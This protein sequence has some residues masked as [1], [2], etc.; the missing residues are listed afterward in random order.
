MTTRTSI[1]Q[2]LVSYSNAKAQIA[3]LTRKLGGMERAQSEIEESLIAALR[4]QGLETAVSAGVEVS[5]GTRLSLQVSDPAMWAEWV[6]ENRAVEFL[7]WTGLRISAVEQYELDNGE[8]PPGLARSTK[9]SV[10]VGRA[11]PQAITTLLQP[12]SKTLERTPNRTVTPE[13]RLAVQ[14]LRASKRALDQFN[15]TDRTPSKPE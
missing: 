14:K 6:I 11:G 2:L 1:A 13:M 7:D 9:P 15:L 8:L 10:V 12:P 4:E 5:I 3:E